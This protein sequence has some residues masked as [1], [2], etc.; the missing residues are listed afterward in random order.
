MK[1]NQTTDEKGLTGERQCLSRRKFLKLSGTATAG[2]VLISVIPGYGSSFLELVQYQRTKIGTLSALQLDKPVYFNYPDISPNAAAMLIRMGKEAGLGVG[3]LKDV[4]AFS[5]LCPHMGGPVG[6]AY[7]PEHK[8]AGPC[9]LHFTTFDLRKH[10]MVISGHSVE[11]LP[12]IQLEV[13]GDNI[14][15]TGIMGL[16]YGYPDNNIN[17]KK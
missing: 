3:P 8:A 7:K 17:V 15:A 6:H 9:P 16:I 11:S 13:E 5:T 10:G 1:D 2:A 14:Y 12:Q 4:V